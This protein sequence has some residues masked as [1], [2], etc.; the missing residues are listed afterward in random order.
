MTHEMKRLKAEIA[1]LRKEN[2]QLKGQQRTPANDHRPSL[3]GVTPLTTLSFVGCVTSTPI[4]NR[5]FPQNPYPPV[6]STNDT[7]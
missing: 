6:N 4:N 1:E 5:D 3:N 2:Q 7:C